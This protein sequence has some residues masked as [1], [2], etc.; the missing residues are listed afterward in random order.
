VGV[1]DGP[2][3]RLHGDR[4]LPVRRPS[5]GPQAGLYVSRTANTASPLSRAP[6]DARIQRL[7]ELA[8]EGCLAAVVAAAE[9]SERRA[10]TAAAYNVVWPIVFARITRR[11]EQRRG[12]WNCATGIDHLADECIDRFHDDVEAVVDDLLT[13]ARQPV[14]NLEAWITGRLNA[15]T[16][17][18][19]RRRRGMR[20]ALQRPRL[21]G[22]LVDDLN[23]DRWLMAL[24]T[25]ILVWV[26]VSHTAGN[27][28]WPLETWAQERARFTGDWKDS[29]PSVVALEVETVLSAMRR[30]PDWYES[31]VERPLGRKQAPVAAL[32]VEDGTGPAAAPLGLGDPYASV[33]TEML[34]LAGDAV[35][36]I[37]RRLGRGQETRAIVVE[38]IRT[39]FGGTFTGTL[40]QAPHDVADPLGGVTGALADQS[41]VNRIVATVRD[42]I[43]E[44]EG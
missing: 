2:T 15:A 39:V 23:H 6:A 13:H 40:D 3:R 41:T 26:G 22:W 35:G 36:A 18:G 1:S 5:N 42:I 17:D 24:A 7:R 30:R 29:D 44:R 8:R 21:P 16:V 34:R 19:H 12:H 38:V 4:V 25:R 9:G 11:V 33:E 43:S 28:V 14:L 37:D 10:L 20:G 27:D 32:P 31:Y